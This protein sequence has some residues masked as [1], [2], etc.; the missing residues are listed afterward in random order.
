MAERVVDTRVGE[1]S[2]PKGHWLGLQALLTK[3]YDPDS[4]E[5]VFAEWWELQLQCWVD[6]A[7][8]VLVHC[9]CSPSIAFQGSYHSSSIAQLACC[10]GLCPLQMCIAVHKQNL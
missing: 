4:L 8:Y 7:W 10:P 9:A 1:G 3:K 6:I 5:L 2:P